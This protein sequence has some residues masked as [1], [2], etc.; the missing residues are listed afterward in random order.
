MDLKAEFSKRAPWITHYEIDGVATGGDFHA[1]NDSRVGEFFETFPRVR[2]I[3]E[4]GSL[5]GGHTFTMARRPDVARVVGLDGRPTNI[6]KS[7]FMQQLFGVS[8][9]EFAE[10]NLEKA[11]L[12]SFGKFDAVFCSGLLYHLP[13]PWKL[14]E[15]VPRVAPNLFIWTHYCDDLAIDA[16]NGDLKGRNY[17]EGDLQS[18]NSGMSATSFWLTLGS[19]T[20]TL[21]KNGFGKIRI[22]EN[23]LSHP[24][25]PAVTLAATTS[26][27]QS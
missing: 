22:L 18:P 17:V 7:R 19:L 12:S 11:E 8:R 15:Q 1:L 3:L 25:G 24:E 27:F 21:T 16:A 14:I 6:E 10:A 2:N 20:K 4:L 5:E 13:E 9:V 23:N 26:R